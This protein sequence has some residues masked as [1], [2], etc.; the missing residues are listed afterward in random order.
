MKER[1]RKG[2]KK[3]IAP[4][5]LYLKRNNGY[6]A[7]EAPLAFIPIVTSSNFSAHC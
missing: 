2:K 5:H 1:N 3:T 6:L 7:I 4:L